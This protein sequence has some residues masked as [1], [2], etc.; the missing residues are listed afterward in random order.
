MTNVRLTTKEID[1]GERVLHDA[2][3][4]EPHGSQ[5]DGYWRSLTEAI[6][7]ATSEEAYFRLTFSRDAS[8]I[9][10]HELARFLRCVANAV[11]DG[12]REDALYLGAQVI[13]F[14]SF[15]ERRA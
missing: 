15:G 7:E 13:G 2:L 8:D 6:L 5:P 12:Q 9:S 14:Y 1:A 3:S 11:E 10:K 4:D